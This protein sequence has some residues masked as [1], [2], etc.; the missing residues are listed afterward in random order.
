VT[1]KKRVLRKIER[2][3]EEQLRELERKLDTLKKPRLSVEKELRLWRDIS[4]MLADPDDYAEFE[5]AARRRPLFGGRT[6][7]LEPDEA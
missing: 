1:V 2:M 3:N 5:A 7:E 4:G 6:L